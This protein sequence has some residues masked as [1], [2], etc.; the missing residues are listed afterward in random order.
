MQDNRRNKK[1]VEPVNEN[2]RAREVM[3][4]DE[5]TGEKLG[6]MP[7]SEAIAKAQAQGLDLYCVAP[8]AKPAVCKILDYGKYKYNLK[9]SQKEA[10]KK[11]TII[12]IKEIRLK[13][14]VGQH[15][16]ETKA[17]RAKEF[18][19][20]GNKVKLS[21][22]FSGR[23]MNFRELGKEVLLKF[24]DIVKDL[25]EWEKEPYDNGRFMDAF[26]KPKRGGNKNAKNEN[27]ESISKE[28]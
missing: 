15:D 20:D 12:V 16:L 26:I 9:K 4:I 6:V 7:T 28:S 14:Q 17:K 2:I 25:G 18:L 5:A 11:Q 23:Q 22:K 19:K 1:V 24:Y 3:V 10:K 13:P 27:K 8:T 21:L